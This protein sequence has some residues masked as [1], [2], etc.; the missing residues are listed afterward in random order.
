[1]IAPSLLR[2]QS[3]ACQ[4]PSWQAHI[5]TRIST[6]VSHADSDLLGLEWS[7]FELK[8]TPVQIGTFSNQT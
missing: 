6:G 5:V 7:E 1:M 4:N 8:S 3:I 2:L